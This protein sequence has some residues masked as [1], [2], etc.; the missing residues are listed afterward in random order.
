MNAA[1]QN[2]K[3]AYKMHMFGEMAYKA[4]NKKSCFFMAAMDYDH[5]VSEGMGSCCALDMD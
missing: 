4:R 2:Y 1:F 3:T 5:I